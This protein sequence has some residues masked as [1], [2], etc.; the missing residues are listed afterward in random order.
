MTPEQLKSSLTQLQSV[1]DVTD[2][3]HDAEYLRHLMRLALQTSNDAE[4][5]ELFQI[6]RQEMPD[7]IKTLQRAL[8]RVIEHERQ[9]AQTPT[10]ENKPP[11]K[12]R[13]ST[14]LSG[15]SMQTMDSSSSSSASISSLTAKDTLH[16]EFLECGIDALRRMSRGVE[17]SLPSWTI[18]KYVSLPISDL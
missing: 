7:A 17:T 11:M 6:K 4:M 13:M 1:Q 18:T 2:R 3:A 8:E 5:L 9:E 14:K 16:R 12:R 15:R 10:V